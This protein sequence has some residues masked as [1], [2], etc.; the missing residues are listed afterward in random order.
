MS[1]SLLKP[2]KGDEFFAPIVSESEEKPESIQT[3]GTFIIF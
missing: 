2:T 1:D 3:I